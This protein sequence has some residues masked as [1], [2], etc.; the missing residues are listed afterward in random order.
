MIPIL[1]AGGDPDQLDI[2]GHLTDPYHLATPFGA[3]DLQAS[4]NEPLKGLIGFDPHISVF[5][6]MMW[7]ASAI[8]ILTATAAA[9]WWAKAGPDAAPGGV[10]NLIEPVLLFVRDQLV[11]PQLGEKHGRRWT[12]FFWTVFFFILTVN[13]VGLLPAPWGIAASGNVSV[14]VALALMTLFAIIVGGT[15]EKGALGFWAGLVPHGVPLY[16]WP[17]VFLIEVFGL[18]AKHLA[19]TVRLFANMTAGHVIILALFSF[20]FL[21]K[22]FAIGVVSLGGVVAITLFEIFVSFVQAYIFTT[23]SAIFIGAGLSHEH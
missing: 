12:P 6:L 9:R 13:L 8:L 10:R 19:L 3:V 23:L 1:A 15:V 7:T 20:I 22:S 11:Y 2:I 5:V 4:I 17:L 18:L 21:S 16:L 14:T